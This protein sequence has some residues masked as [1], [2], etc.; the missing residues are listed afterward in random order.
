MQFPLS[1]EEMSL[2][3]AIMSL[4]LMIA[5]EFVSPYNGQINLMIDKGRL[6]TVALISSAIYLGTIIIQ[7][8]ETLTPH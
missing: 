7:V 4:V 5:A 1:L 6:R 2:W 8:Y 3:L